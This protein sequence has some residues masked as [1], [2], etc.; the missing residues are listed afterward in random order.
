MF[1]SVFS[2]S[3]T[4]AIDNK[5]EQAMVSYNC[6]SLLLSFIMTIWVIGNGRIRVSKQINN[7]VGK[8]KEYWMNFINF[9]V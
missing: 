8:Q 3:S 1:L 9:L 5:I 2:G 6:T 4:V 7:C